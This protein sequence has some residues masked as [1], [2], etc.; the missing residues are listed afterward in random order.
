MR[1]SYELFAEDAV[2]FLGELGIDKA[3]VVGFGDG[4]CTGLLL[5]IEHP[6]LVGRLVCIGTPYNTSNYREGIVDLFAKITPETLY[7]MVGP[8]FLEVMK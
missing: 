6:E 1:G 3:H 2:A 8:E 5:G 4:G 7:R